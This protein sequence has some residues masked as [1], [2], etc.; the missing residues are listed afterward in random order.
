[1]AHVYHAQKWHLV[2]MDLSEKVLRVDIDGALE[3]EQP[4]SNPLPPDGIQLE[5]LHDSA[6]LFDNLQICGLSD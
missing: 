4:D 6:A 2:M 5:R 1:M 3:I